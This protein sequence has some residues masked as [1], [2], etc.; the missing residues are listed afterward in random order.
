LQTNGLV[1]T[2]LKKQVQAR[3]RLVNI[4]SQEGQ[5]NLDLGEVLVVETTTG[6]LGDVVMGM[7]V[8]ASMEEVVGGLGD[9]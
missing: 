7:V 1:P 4:L 6:V 2:W 5:G 3:G 8:G 9:E